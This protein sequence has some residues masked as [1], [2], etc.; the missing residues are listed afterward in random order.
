MG[1]AGR[2]LDQAFGGGAGFQPQPQP[3][4]P[5]GNDSILNILTDILRGDGF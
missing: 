2:V 3:P 1:H 4:A 5:Q